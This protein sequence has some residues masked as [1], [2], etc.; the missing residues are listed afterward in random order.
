[1]L[2]RRQQTFILLFKEDQTAG[3]IPQKIEKKNLKLREIKK[4][5]AMIWVISTDS[6]SSMLAINNNRENYLILNQIYNILAELHKQRKQIIL[7]KVPA[8]IE[9]EEVAK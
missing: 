3:D 4:R 2:L 1:M 5:E 8:H 6:M 9:N 7:C